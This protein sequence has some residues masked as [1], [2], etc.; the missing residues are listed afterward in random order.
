MASTIPP[1]D[2]ILWCSGPTK[3]T[4]W[5]ARNNL[6]LE[7]CHHLVQQTI[8]VESIQQLA[9]HVDGTALP[10]GPRGTHNVQSY[11]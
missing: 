8:L 11:V 10:Q 3:I 1:P 5:L 4:A 2:K 9:G 6:G 7:F